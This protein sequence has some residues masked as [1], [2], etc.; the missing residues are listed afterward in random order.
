M[1][2]VAL[3]TLEMPG[4]SRSTGRQSHPKGPLRTVDN[5]VRERVRAALAAKGWEQKDLA[6][7]LDVAPATITNLLKPGPVRQIKFLPQL[8]KLLGLKDELEEVNEAWPDLLPEVKA[9]IA[10]LVRASKIK[11]LP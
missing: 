1:V 10:A 8:L 3:S 5:V 7:K 4:S 9:A 6:V 11:P 2:A